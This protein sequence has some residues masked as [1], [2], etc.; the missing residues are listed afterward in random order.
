MGN[1]N[2]L[3]FC[4]LRVLNLPFTKL[5]PIGEGVGVSEDSQPGGIH[6]SSSHLQP[7]T[8]PQEMFERF[9][10]LPQHK[11]SPW[12]YPT[13][14]IL[15]HQSLRFKPYKSSR[16]SNVCMRPISVSM[17]GTVRACWLKS[18]KFAKSITNFSFGV[19]APFSYCTILTSAVLSS[20]R[21]CFVCTLLLATK[22][23]HR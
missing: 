12:V 14:F 17:F 20:Y 9:L 5:V 21:L 7:W 11:S 10:T 8:T 19:L 3:E 16:V 15:H 23:A 2:S 22:G 4:T 1:W 18:S 6:F 13:A